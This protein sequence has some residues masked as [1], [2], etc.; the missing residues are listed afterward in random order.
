[1]DG[2]GEYISTAFMDY[3]KEHGIVPRISTTNR[4][5]M[6][7]V[8]ERANRTIEEHTTAMLQEAVRATLPIS[9]QG[10]LTQMKERVV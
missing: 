10:Y 5:Q 4:P 7:G 6:N 8:A 2:G 3:L 9:R 1:M